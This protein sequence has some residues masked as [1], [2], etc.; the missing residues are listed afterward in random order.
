MVFWK[1][2]LKIFL[3]LCKFGRTPYPAQYIVRVYPPLKGKRERK[4]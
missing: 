4:E 1:K 3:I 2:K